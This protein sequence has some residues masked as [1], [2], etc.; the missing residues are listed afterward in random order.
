MQRESGAPGGTLGCRGALFCC[1]EDQG[2]TRS[3]THR[4]FSSQ[5]WLLVSP[6]PMVLVRI[7]FQHISLSL[8]YSLSDCVCAQRVHHLTLESMS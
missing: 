1:A 7:C 4:A 6:F 2:L 3:P 8:L 5:R